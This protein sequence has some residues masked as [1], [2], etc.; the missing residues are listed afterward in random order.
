[1]LKEGTLRHGSKDSQDC[2]PNAATVN[3]PPGPAPVALVT[4]VA[5][6]AG[7]Y[8]SHPSLLYFRHPQQEAVQILL[9]SYTAYLLVALPCE[10]ESRLGHASKGSLD[11]LLTPDSAQVSHRQ[12]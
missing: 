11:T 1:M 8:I 4:F 3:G 5:I 9:V 7:L 10:P 2:G 6:T 12:R